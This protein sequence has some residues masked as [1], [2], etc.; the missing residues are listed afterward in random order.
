MVDKGSFWSLRKGRWRLC[1]V[2]KAA[3]RRPKPSDPHKPHTRVD[4]THLFCVCC[5]AMLKIRGEGVS[6]A[7]PADAAGLL[8]WFLRICSSVLE[9]Q[10]Q[11]FVSSLVRES[12]TCCTDFPHSFWGIAG[13]TERHADP[14][15]RTQCGPSIRWGDAAP[16][17]AVIR[18]SDGVRAHNRRRCAWDQ[19]RHLRQVPSVADSACYRRRRPKGCCQLCSLGRGGRRKCA[20]RTYLVCVELCAASWVRTIV[21][22][23]AP[24]AL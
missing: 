19:E 4:L 17:T 8:A 3:K 11:R 21:P 5:T 18:P 10:C 23:R 16:T 2:I 24:S 1:C 7:T 6:W 14:P 13:A 15:N 22:Q 9:Q 20:G 12:C